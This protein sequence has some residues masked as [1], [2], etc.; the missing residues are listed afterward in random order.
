MEENKS[1]FGLPVDAEAATSLND[2]GRWA[3]FLSVVGFCFM[4]LMLLLFALFGSNITGTVSNIFEFNASGIMDVFIVVIIFFA[5]IAALLLYFLFKGANNIRKG[6]RYNDQL[7]LNDGLAN[8]R[9]FF[10][11]YGVISV[12]F[13]G[14]QLFGLF[15][16]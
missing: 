3:K 12:I 11:M 10:V 7:I 1:L 14:F 15:Q 8:L 2:T 16:N 9:N 5:S 6:M 4:G 13:L